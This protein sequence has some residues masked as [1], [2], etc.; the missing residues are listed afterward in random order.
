MS[1]N[2]QAA[3]TLPSRTL[4]AEQLDQLVAVARSGTAADV[5]DLLGKFAVEAARAV[6]LLADQERLA[7]CKADA[8][9]AEHWRLRV[10][11]LL[12]DALPDAEARYWASRIVSL[13]YDFP[14]QPLARPCP[15]PAPTYTVVDWNYETD[16]PVAEMDAI[17]AEYVKTHGR[18]PDAEMSATVRKVKEMLM[19][20]WN[21]HREAIRAGLVG[22]LPDAARYEASNA[23]ACLPNDQKEGARAGFAAARASLIN[24][25]RPAGIYHGATPET[26]C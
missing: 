12:E 4:N 11:G 2:L 18:L 21:W 20:W 17:L 15:I 14:E 7:A 3:A 24:G 1:N 10:T 16:D 6:P 19:T 26:T 23:F 5:S 8:S 25:P 13:L 22:G 9:L